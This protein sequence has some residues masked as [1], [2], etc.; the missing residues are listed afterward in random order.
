MQ[1]IAVI[2][3]QSRDLDPTQMQVEDWQ[4]VQRLA[5]PTRQQLDAGLHAE[6]SMFQK[7]V[8][9]VL[10]PEQWESYVVALRRPLVRL[11]ISITK[12]SL[13][14]LQPVLALTHAQ[15]EAIVGLITDSQVPQNVPITGPRW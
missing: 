14:D 6:G 10:T 3:F 5:M 4:K 8:R 2:E 7:S 9:T 11:C 13:L 15:R 1:E 12:L